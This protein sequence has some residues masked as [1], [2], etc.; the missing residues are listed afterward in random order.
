MNIGQGEARDVRAV[1]TGTAAILRHLQTPILFGNV[2]PG[3]RKRRTI[4]GRLDVVTRAGEGELVVSLVSAGSLRTKL[5]A[6]KKFLV[7]LR[8]KQA[9]S[10][11]FSFRP[12]VVDASGEGRASSLLWRAVDQDITGRKHRNGLTPETAPK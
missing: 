7:T 5:P 11:L 10:M 1:L 6:R 12:S 8:P 4:S 2:Q 9:A 3:Q